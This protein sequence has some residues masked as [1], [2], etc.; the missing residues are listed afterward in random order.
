VIGADRDGDN[1]RHPFCHFD[2]GVPAYQLQESRRFIAG[3]DTKEFL[4]LI[5]W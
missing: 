5:H 4:C 1:Q 3:I 2:F